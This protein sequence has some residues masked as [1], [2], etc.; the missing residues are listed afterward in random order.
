[1]T[2]PPQP[3]ELATSCPVSHT[4]VDAL[5]IDDDVAR[6]R[7]M[8]KALQYYTV[9]GMCCARGGTARQW[10]SNR[11]HHAV[12]IVA[13]HQSVSDMNMAALAHRIRKLHPHLPVYAILL[14]CTDKM[15][16]ACIRADVSRL[17]ASSKTPTS[18]VPGIVKHIQ[19]LREP[20]K[21]KLSQ[22]SFYAGR[23]QT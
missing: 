10:L 17:F 15:I 19:S 16:S 12:S 5:Y 4:Y 18:L 2:T 9:S 20:H 6:R 11:D 3:Y 7:E 13:V 22:L 23:I 8:Q 14:H 21:A 1:M